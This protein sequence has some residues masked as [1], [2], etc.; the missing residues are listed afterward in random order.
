M[1]WEEQVNTSHRTHWDRGLTQEFLNIIGLYWKCSRGSRG[2]GT[3]WG[4]KNPRR[5]VWHSIKRAMGSPLG[6]KDLYGWLWWLELCCLQEPGS[7]ALS[8]VKKTALAPRRGWLQMYLAQDPVLSILDL[9]LFSFRWLF[10]KA[11][12][13]HGVQ[14]LLL[15]LQ[16]PRAMVRKAVVFLRSPTV[17][18]LPV[19]QMIPYAGS[20]PPVKVDWGWEILICEASESPLRWSHSSQT[21]KL[22]EREWQLAKATELVRVRHLT[23]APTLLT[24]STILKFLI[25]QMICFSWFLL[26]HHFST[27]GA[28]HEIYLLPSHIFVEIPLLLTP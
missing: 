21:G 22:Q 20:P 12:P 14:R 13:L 27:P 16:T 4:I 19:T 5:N 11:E 9:A 2:E 15:P 8:R 3:L 1:Q 25:K 18:W 23:L 6:P 24:T 26:T 17:F 10:P 28:P 7:P